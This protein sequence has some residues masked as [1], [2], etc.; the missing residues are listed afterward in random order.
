MVF[1]VLRVFK[2]TLFRQKILLRL[3]PRLP[4][5]TTGFHRLNTIENGF[6]SSFPPLRT[7]HLIKNF[8]PRTVAG[9]IA[10]ID[11]TVANQSTQTSSGLFKAGSIF[12][13]FIVINGSPSALLESNPNND[14]AVY[15]PFLGA[16]TDKVDHIRLL[17]N[18]TFGF[19]DL[20]SGGDFDYNDII[21]K[22]KLT[23]VA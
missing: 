23:P 10:G 19:E 17:G 20:P 9:Q 6:S 14:P 2:N 12:A 15:F 13:P 4:C 7:F 16:N 1:L 8:A 22:V 11:L 3:T 21:V 5:L 18:N